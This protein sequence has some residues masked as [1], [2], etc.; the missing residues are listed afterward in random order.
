MKILVTI[1]LITPA[2]QTSLSIMERKELEVFLNIYFISY[3]E[4]NQQRLENR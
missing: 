4:V 3:F 1:H 2:V